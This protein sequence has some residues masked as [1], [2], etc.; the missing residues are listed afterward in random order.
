[1]NKMSNNNLVS[2]A[3]A[4]ALLSLATL[5]VSTSAAADTD[6]RVGGYIKLDVMTSHFDDGT[7]PSGSIGRDFYIPGLTP[8]GGGDSSTVTDFHARES[9]FFFEAKQTLSNG[10]TISGYVEFDFLGTAGGDKRITNSYSPRVRHA[11]I[12]YRNW[13]VGQFWSNFQETAIIPEAPDFVGVAD[14]IVF[15][16]Q[17]QIRYTFDNGLSV[18]VEAPETTV[19]PYQGGTGRITSGDTAMPDLTARWATKLDNVYFSI[20]GI[21]RRLELRQQGV[22]DTENAFGASLA[23]KWDIGPHDIRTS[24]VHGSGLGRYVGINVAN[25][26]II[27]E[28]LNLDAIDVTGFS[29]AYR[30]VWSEKWRTNLIYS[31]ADIDNQMELAGP[32]AN[33]STQRYAINM[34]YQV[35]ERLVVGGEY[36]SAN[37]E[38][39]SG[40]DGNMD[41]VQFSAQYSF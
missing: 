13:R 38:L 20:A 36:S 21:Y 11:F 39:L 16:R 3:V 28:D 37:R 2:S 29:F 18:S 34:M 26:A 31:R 27:N 9:R 8:V 1:M 19:T 22:D 35:N 30:H 23:M 10:E 6:Y 24:V 15:N 41:R 17:P 25:G 5:G 33:D 32:V 40:A 12:D 4:G 14:G 7:L